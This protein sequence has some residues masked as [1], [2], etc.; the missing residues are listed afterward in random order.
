MVTPNWL[1]PRWSI[2]RR[3]AW[4]RNAPTKTPTISATPP[5][6]R[7]ENAAQAIAAHSALRTTGYSGGLSAMRSSSAVTSSGVT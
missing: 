2:V 6:F 3:S 1:N 4:P 5:L 7:N